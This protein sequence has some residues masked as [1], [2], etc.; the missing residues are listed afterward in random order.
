MAEDDIQKRMPPLFDI[1]PNDYLSKFNLAGQDIPEVAE[2]YQEATQARE[3]ALKALEDRYK[4]IN[5]FKLAGAFAKPQLGGFL[6]SLGSAA[7]V[8]GEQTE[9]ERAIQPTIGMMRAQLATERALLTQKS[10]QEKELKKYEDD[11]K[12]GQPQDLDRLRRIISL[13][14]DSPV[15]KSLETKIGAL[16]PE[17]RAETEFGVGLQKK[18]LDN[19]ALILTDETYRGLV[20]TEEKRVEYVN[21]VNSARPQGISPA[22]WNAMGFSE[23]EAAIAKI[24]NQ[25]ALVSLEEGQKS[26]VRAEDGQQVLNQLSE[27]RELAVDPKLKPVFALFSDG[28]LFSQFRAYLDKNPGRVNDAVEGLVNATMNKLANADETTRAKFDSLV[29]GI[30]RLELRMRGTMNNPT[31]AAMQVSTM[32]APSLVNSQAGF[33]KIIDSL[34]LN[35]YR[36]IEM[37]R[38]RT[39]RKLTDQDLLASDDMKDFNNQMRERTRQ[40]SVSNPLTEAPDFFYPGRGQPKTEPVKTEPAPT[41]AA[42]KPTNQPAGSD[43]LNRFR[44]ELNLR[45]KQP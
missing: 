14:P 10:V 2:A 43:R 40:L 7:D 4:K 18:F 21:K 31:D 24:G 36:D 42:S 13:A 32:A 39:N 44:N 29:K 38:L 12:A 25:K 23:R 8:L 41:A 34:G 17:R 28:D 15:A 20:P 27:L 22:E 1:K 6:A 35:A 33:L 45:Q 19:P 9:A 26:A 5:Y 3:N 16:Q 11:V 37:H 30:K